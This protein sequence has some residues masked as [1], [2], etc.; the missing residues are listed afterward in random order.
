[1][2]LNDDSQEKAARLQSRQAFR[3]L[4]INQLRA[5]AAGTPMKARLPN[6][7]PH[8][9]Q[10]GGNGSQDDSSP[11][12]NVVG[13]LTPMKRVPILANFEEW[14]KMATDNKI[15]ANN[16][17]NFALIDYFHDLSLLKEG[18]GVN[19]QKASCTLD[20][21]VK[22]Y[23]SRV[24]SV[25]TET[26]KLLSGLAEGSSKKKKEQ[27]GAEEGEEDG[28]AGEEDEEAG[29]KKKAKRK[30][31]RS[32]ETTLVPSFESLRLKKFELEFSVDPLFKKMSADFDEGGAKGLLLNHLSQDNTGRIVFDSSEDP[33]PVGG[34]EGIDGEGNA[35][36]DASQADQEER[37]TQHQDE[38]LLDIE[39]LGAKFFP[40][41]D[42]LDSQ[43][44]C[45]SLKTFALGDSEGTLDL[46]FLRPSADD[47]EKDDGPAEEADSA[48]RDPGGFDDSDNDMNMGG[49]DV[50][51]EEGGAAFGEGG[52]A[53]AK[54]AMLEPLQQSIPLTDEMDQGDGSDPQYE[55]PDSASGTYGISMQH[56]SSRHQP[57]SSTADILSYFDNA[58]SSK[59]SSWAGP[60]HWRIRRIKQQSSSSS[61]SSSN[62]PAP[63]IRKADKEPFQIDFLAP[64]PRSIAEQLY[65]PAPSPTAISL[66]RSQW[67]SRTRNLLPDDKHFNSRDLLRLALKPRAR[68][69]LRHGSQRRMV[70]GVL[71]LRMSAEGQGQGQPDSAYWAR[72]KGM[73]ER[74]NALMGEDEDDAPR[75]GDYDANFF[76]EDDTRFL[77]RPAGMNSDADADDDDNFADAREHFSA[78]PAPEAGSSQFPQ[79]NR[80]LDAALHP[81]GGSSSSS[82]GPPL[83]FGSQ[84]VTQG[85]RF[86]PEYVRFAKVAKKVDVKRLKDAMWAGL[87][88]EGLD[89]RVGSVPDGR[90]RAGE[91]G[92][93]TPEST[94]EPEDDH[95]DEDED[96]TVHD[97]L[98]PVTVGDGGGGSGIKFSSIMAGLKSRYDKQSYADIST[99]YGFI[100]L[101]HLCNEQGLELKGNGELTE[102]TI[103][104]DRGGGG[105]GR[106][107]VA[108]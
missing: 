59:S 73:D 15:N 11:R 87:M 61:S 49:F 21:C 69:G 1:M 78:P 97:T 51:E 102:L 93:P 4:N 108:S 86:R 56:P 43:D 85:R 74:Q 81:S 101:L 90:G 27:D 66:P 55:A 26:G 23:T 71:A 107:V 36:G 94:P 99:S 105:G 64:L 33:A 79:P 88:G 95:G 104:R 83:A 14:M 82:Q 12:L 19:F 44:I 7:S 57:Q 32:S 24:D 40:D 75:Q 76:H 38:A 52:E 29:K 35:N 22:I 72:K 62:Q 17:W 31:A 39:G 16:S 48:S 25:A 98:D 47:W 10:R 8:T 9:P 2:P 96:K 20:G 41:L 77:P 42:L 92:L 67:R 28:E 53:W 18:D 5:A 106:S 58:L 60:E 3:E 37:E 46:P 89:E 50:V 54:Q 13:V 100:C 84:L 6:G 68:I 103:V 45:P 80:S 91:G 30:A 34:P 65:T 63:R 70:G